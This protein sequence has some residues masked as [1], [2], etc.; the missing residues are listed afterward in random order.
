MERRTYPYRPNYA[1]PPGYVLEDHLD[2]KGFT[3][4][5][6]ARRHSLPAD[7]IEGI[8]NGRAPI[9][10]DLAALFGREFSLAAGMWLRMEA[11]YRSRLEQ[12]ERKTVTEAAD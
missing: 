4:A 6:F 7:L 3:P 2:A 10:E 1:T 11:T 8:I 9:D 5:E 12:L